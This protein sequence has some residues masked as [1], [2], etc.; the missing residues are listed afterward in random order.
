[1]L[2]HATVFNYHGYIHA[3]ILIRPNCLTH[4]YFSTLW[5]YKILLYLRLYIFGLTLVNWL[6]SITLTFTNSIIY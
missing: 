5:Q 2:F 6:S 1:M 4:Y 3:T